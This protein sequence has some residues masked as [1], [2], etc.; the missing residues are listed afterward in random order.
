MATRRLRRRRLRTV[1]F[2]SGARRDGIDIS[3]AVFAGHRSLYRVHTLS[4]PQD[5]S[6]RRSAYSLPFA[7]SEIYDNRRARD[8]DN[9][10]YPRRFSGIEATV[11]SG[12]VSSSDA[13]PYRFYFYAPRGVVLCV[14]REQRRRVIFARGSAGNRV[15]PPRFSQDSLISCN[16]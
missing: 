13:I 14:R 2:L 15:K 10:S 12:K 9:R 5:M 11:K 16:S 1:S 8:F 4:Y 6:R 3:P 7:W